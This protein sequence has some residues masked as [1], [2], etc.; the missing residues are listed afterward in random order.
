M[1]R[2]LLMR[3]TEQKDF[4]LGKT[5]NKKGSEMLLDNP[6][7]KEIIKAF[8]IL[9]EAVDLKLCEHYYEKENNC[10]LN[11][12]EIVEEFFKRRFPD[13]NL[14]FEKK[15]GYFDKWMDRFRGGHPEGFADDYSL[16]VME[17]MKKEGI[18]WR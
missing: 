15:C 6:T 8:R 4:K 2:L 12:K 10:C 11:T 17:E 16:K 14:E 1:K 13:K 7:Q 18:K 9:K 3:Y 5:N